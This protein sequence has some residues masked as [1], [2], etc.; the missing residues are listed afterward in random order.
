LKALRTVYKNNG[1]LYDGGLDAMI[2]DPLTAYE[3]LIEFSFSALIQQGSLNTFSSAI[4]RIATMEGIDF[5][6]MIDDAGVTD[7]TRAAAGLP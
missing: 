4:N 7:A 3:K 2:Y 1:I 6:K 5:P